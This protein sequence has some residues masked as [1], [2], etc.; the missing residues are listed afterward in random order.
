MNAQHEFVYDPNINVIPGSPDS[1][2]TIASDLLDGIEELFQDDN[3]S[4]VNNISE[5]PIYFDDG[6]VVNNEVE[7]FTKSGE[8]RKRKKYLTSVEMRK[9]IKLDLEKDRQGVLPGCD[10]ENCQKQCYR[11]ITE[12]RRFDVNFQYWNMTWK[13][14]RVFILST[15]QCVDVKTRKNTELT[16]FINAL[17]FYITDDQGIKIQVCKPFFLTTLG[18]KKTNDRVLDILRHYPNG[19]VEAPD[20]LRGKK[21]TKKSLFL[22]YLTFCHHFVFPRV[23]SRNHTRYNAF[24]DSFK[25]AKEKARRAQITS[26]LSSADEQPKRSLGSAK[27]KYLPPPT[28]SENSDADD[29]DKTFSP[30]AN[31]D[32]NMI[33]KKVI[34]TNIHDQN[35]FI[36][37]LTDDLVGNTDSSS[38]VMPVTPTKN[39]AS[40][41]ALTEM[42]CPDDITSNNPISFSIAI[43]PVTPTSGN[44]DDFQNLLKHL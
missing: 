28:F 37:W 25:E 32:C 16:N 7:L 1:T 29:S 17:K 40:T 33:Q 18:F 10:K 8:L 27:K 39:I 44:Y 20:D 11:K 24:K 31:H 14:R 41:S 26:D 23:S 36:E 9:K 12:E 21:P 3:E 5:L 30:H 19:Q 13:E 35:D 6:V 15:C 4:V 2:I 38:V 42:K 43:P 34:N 22:Y